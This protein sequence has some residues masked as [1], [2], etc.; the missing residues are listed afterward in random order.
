LRLNDCL[1]IMADD[2][3]EKY[4]EVSAFLNEKKRK[5]IAAAIAAAN[6]KRKAEQQAA[7]ANRAVKFFSYSFFS[8]HMITF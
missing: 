6:L 8:F 7:R 2:Y 1:D 5:S 4:K 3:P